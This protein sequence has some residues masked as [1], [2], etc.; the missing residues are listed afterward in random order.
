M[1]GQAVVAHLTQDSS[2][3]APDLCGPRSC[4][5]QGR[6]MGSWL[7]AIQRYKTTDDDGRGLQDRD[8]GRHVLVDVSPLLCLARK[9]ISG[10]L[11]CF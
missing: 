4:Y 1:S 10:I 5:R 9:M 6:I 3:C 8:A 2:T 7:S 11:T